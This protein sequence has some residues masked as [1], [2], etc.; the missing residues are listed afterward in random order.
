MAEYKVC[1]GFY[2]SMRYLFFIHRQ[3][4]WYMPDPFMQ[5]N[6]QNIAAGPEVQ[7]ILDH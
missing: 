2:G 7:D 1:A 4:G 6:Y 3:H 5:S